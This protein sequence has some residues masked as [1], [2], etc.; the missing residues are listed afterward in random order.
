MA[1]AETRDQR[2]A[3]TWGTPVGQDCINLDSALCKWLGERLVFMGEHTSSF[4]GT[5]ETLDAWRS[6]LTFHGKR[7][8]R[9]GTTE[10]SDYDD[11][12]RTLEWVGKHLPALWD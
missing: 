2:Y 5:Y 10:E 6:D 12:R 11:V 4:S 7:L 9:Y 8:L 3:R 1:K